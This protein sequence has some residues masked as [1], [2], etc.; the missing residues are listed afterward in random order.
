ML[1]ANNNCTETIPWDFVSLNISYSDFRDIFS[2]SKGVSPSGAD[3]RPL[4]RGSRPL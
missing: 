2:E 4:S 1:S 3:K